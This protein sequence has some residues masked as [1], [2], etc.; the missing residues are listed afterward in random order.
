MTALENENIRN[1]DERVSVIS[2][3]I[4]EIKIALL[5]DAYNK[6]GVI[7]RLESFEGD[8]K[9]LQLSINK[10]ETE[11]KQSD[12]KKNLLFGIGAALLTIALNLSHII[13]LFKK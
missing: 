4:K 12:Y 7:P 10:L 1:L 2:D 6:H 11:K 5:G 13:E 8:L 3:D 9:K